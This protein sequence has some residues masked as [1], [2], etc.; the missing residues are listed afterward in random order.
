[1]R[2]CACLLNSVCIS[3]WR[4]RRIYRGCEGTVFMS[5]GKQ[6]AG[7]ENP[8]AKQISSKQGHPI[9]KVTDLSRS[10]FFFD[11]RQQN[12]HRRFR[13]HSIYGYHLV[14]SHFVPN[15]N[16]NF[17]NSLTPMMLNFDPSQTPHASPH[18]LRH[19]GREFIPLESRINKPQSNNEFLFSKSA[20]TAYID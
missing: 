5:K 15:Q 19:L 12:R 16:T 18:T 17:A 1:M 4:T 6:T 8:N 2:S 9:H 3:A 13:L 7:H 10:L 14:D 20:N 11:P